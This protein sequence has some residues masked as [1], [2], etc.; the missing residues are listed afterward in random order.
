VIFRR[1]FLSQT[2]V[3]A[4]CALATTR[5]QE[6]PGATILQATPAPLLAEV[7][8]AIPAASKPRL[9]VV[10]GTRP[11]DD[12]ADAFL[13]LDGVNRGPVSRYAETP[14]R[15][16][17]ALPLPAVRPATASAPTGTRPTTGSIAFALRPTPGAAGRVV[18]ERI[19]VI[20][21]A[22]VVCLLKDQA[23]KRPL[24][25]VLQIT[26]VDRGEPPWCGPA[27]EAPREGPAWISDDGG[28][29]LW[30]PLGATATLVGRGSPF[31][32]AVRFRRRLDLAEGLVMTF[33]LPPDQRPDGARILEPLH[34]DRRYHPGLKR[35]D[36]ALDVGARVG[37]E[38]TT[39]PAAEVWA[40]PQAFAV[41]VATNPTAQLVVSNEDAARLVPDRLKPIVTVRLAEGALIHSN[42][43]LPLLENLRREGDRVKAWIKLRCPEDARLD[44]VS[45][46]A[47]A[48][49]RRLPAT[50]PCTLALDV[51]SPPGAPIAIVV[52]GSGFET[53]PPLE[54]P[55][56]VRAILAP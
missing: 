44:V 13:F 54:R 40:D 14:R 29:E 21:A 2:L 6:T 8:F 22:R 15:F 28:G 42:G 37:A 32:A 46:F 36:D 43:P 51:E 56:A 5:A 27:G 9:L 24:R 23:D 7:A 47:G 16:E 19:E 4:A 41:R 50:G 18:V 3:F 11:D 20:D 39:V 26:A 1:H 12:A 52:R 17:A 10:R 34:D 30:T 35:K 38:W 55:F 25:G 48:T 31:R 33:F 49:E 53:A 45:V